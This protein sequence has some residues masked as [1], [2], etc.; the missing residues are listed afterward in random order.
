MEAFLPCRIAKSEL[1]F[2]T[3]TSDALERKGQKPKQEN[4]PEEIAVPS[5]MIVV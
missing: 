3:I 2:V 1:Y 4:N 5:E